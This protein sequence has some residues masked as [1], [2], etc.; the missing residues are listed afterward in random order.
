LR[1][2][3]SFAVI[4]IGDARENPKRDRESLRIV[5]GSCASGQCDWRY[6]C[7]NGIDPAGISFIPAAQIEPFFDVLASKTSF[8]RVNLRRRYA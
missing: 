6:L 1:F 5:T 7:W 3:Q 8:R 2:A 4:F